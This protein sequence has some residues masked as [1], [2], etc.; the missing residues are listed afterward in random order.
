MH[1]T[2]ADFAR[3]R[4]RQTYRSRIG[5][6]SNKK[7]FKRLAGVAGGISGDFFG[8]ALGDDSPAFIAGIRP[9]VNHPIS[10]FNHVNVVFDDQ[11]GMAF[12]HQ[13]LKN[14]Q[15]YSH[16]VEVQARRGLVE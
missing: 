7:I 16:V 12:I 14:F 11:D 10:R 2:S 1:A 4:I 5:F 8:R 13:P 6:N 3:C 15:Q 9:Q